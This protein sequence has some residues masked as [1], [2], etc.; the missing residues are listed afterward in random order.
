ML[1]TLCTAIPPRVIIEIIIEIIHSL[2]R[3]GPSGRKGK[4]SWWSPAC[5]LKAWLS[6]SPGSVPST[7]PG[8][9]LSARSERRQ[10]PGDKVLFSQD[11]VAV[12]VT[13]SITATYGETAGGQ[14]ATGQTS[15]G[16]ARDGA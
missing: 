15:T 8:V 6:L 2:M 11:S 10:S 9:G 16:T 1:S 5:V 12:G 3:N 13:A 4:N 7:R 14:A